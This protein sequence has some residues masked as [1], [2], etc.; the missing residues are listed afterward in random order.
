MIEV[1]FVLRGTRRSIKKQLNKRQDKYMFSHVFIRLENGMIL[2]N[3]YHDCEDDEKLE[4]LLPISS[5]AIYQKY[6]KH[7]NILKPCMTK[8]FRK[9]YTDGYNVKA[10]FGEGM[11]CANMVSFLLGF[12]DYWKHDCDDVYFN[13]LKATKQNN[14]PNQA[15][16]ENQVV[17]R[18][19]VSDIEHLLNTR[20]HELGAADMI[21]VEMADIEKPIYIDPKEN[22]IL[23]GEYTLLKLIRD[24]VL[25]CNVVYATPLYLYHSACNKIYCSMR[26]SE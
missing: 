21:R 4:I 5:K 9:I 6:L 1:V 17:K 15:E 2:D 20:Y 10:L 24:D 13:L 23:H 25:Y 19:L 11:T 8:D 12:K 18:V 7:Q 14:K 3:F 16:N 22:M 26:T